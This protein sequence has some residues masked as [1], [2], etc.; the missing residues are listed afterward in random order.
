VVK[1]MLHSFHQLG[2]IIAAGGSS[3]RFGEG[4]K[5]FQML[6]GLPVFCHCL[7]NF[8]GGGAPDAC[9]LV[10]PANSLENFLLL[11]DQHLPFLTEQVRIIPGGETRMASVLAGLNALPQS[12]RFVAV[13]DAARPLSS[14]ALLQRCLDSARQTGSG[15]AAH[16]LTD[17]IKQATTDGKV[18]KT[19]DRNA[20]WA[21]ETPQVFQR[22]LLL[23][24]YQH[25]R[26]SQ[27]N[28]TDDA[29]LLEETGIPVQ[30]VENPQPNPKITFPTDLAAITQKL[31]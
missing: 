8:L 26:N 2:L 13:Q 15:V 7:K 18:L 5:L 11:L 14:A 10:A 20:L 23:K 30:L 17:T 3:S 12:C 22:E 21:T 27:K 28:F 16:R 31:P 4:N 9:L 25:C 24:A 29:Q 19:L 1:K 6:D